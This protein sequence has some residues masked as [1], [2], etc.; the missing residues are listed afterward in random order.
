MSRNGEALRLTEDHKPNLPRERKRVEVRRGACA[1][2]ACTAWFGSHGGAGRRRLGV[3][4]LCQPVAGCA[5]GMRAVPVPHPKAAAHPPPPVPHPT[6]PQGLGGRVD[7]ARCWRV[8]VDPG[9]GRPASGLAVSRCA[10]CA[11]PH[12]RHA[13]GAAC[14]GL[15]SAP[16][17]S[18]PNL[19]LHQPAT[20][21]CCL[22][23]L[24]PHP[25]A[26]D[27][28]DLC[29]L[30][31][32]PRSSFG[33]PDFKE[34]LHLVTA[35]PDVIRERLLPGDDFVILASDGLVRCAAAAAGGWRRAGRLRGCP[36][37]LGRGCVL[38][39]ASKL[40]RAAAALP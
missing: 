1:V 29:V 19:T 8:I 5:V 22:P 6:A 7:F 4:G 10:G 23:V 2:P 32:H 11:P 17:L 26:P 9:N 21:L 3:G 18:P 14:R 40:G 31:T 28:P 36:P 37:A 30:P 15:P 24:P 13:A 16:P 35:T 27:L 39:R 34:P 33:D 20:P 38:L 25:A 12:G